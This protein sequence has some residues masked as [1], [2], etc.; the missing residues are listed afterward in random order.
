MAES[1]AGMCWIRGCDTPIKTLVRYVP[2]PPDGG[3]LRETV[4]NDPDD[5]RRHI[6]EAHG[7]TKPRRLSPA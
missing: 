7:K 4:I 6:R 3:T 1:R 2:L 5:L